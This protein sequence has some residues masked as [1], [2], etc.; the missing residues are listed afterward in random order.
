ML[1][2]LVERARIAHA[3]DVVG[4]LAAGP[5]DP[6]AFEQVHGELDVEGHFNAGPHDLAIALYR[7]SIA[8]VEQRARYKDGEVDR[9]ACHEAAI[10]HAIPG[11]LGQRAREIE[12]V[13]ATDAQ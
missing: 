1:Q 3:E 2:G 13:R 12:R 5:V 6:L 4:I 9:H 11:R 8:D 7:M 10:I